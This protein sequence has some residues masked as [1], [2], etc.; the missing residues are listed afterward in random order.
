M[1]TVKESLSVA[2]AA[3][4]LYV[5]G[6]GVPKGDSARLLP[7]AICPRPAC[8]KSPRPSARM[9]LRFTRCWVCLTAGPSVLRDTSQTVRT[10][11]LRVEQGRS[12]L[13]WGPMQ[14]R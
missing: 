1:G 4:L 12:V 9:T 7:L 3:P 6:P 8:G 13:R 11:R 10:A 5:G 14:A 2:G